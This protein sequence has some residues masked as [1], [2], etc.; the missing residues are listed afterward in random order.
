M[1]I[2]ERLLQR[3]AEADVFTPFGDELKIA[4]K[5]CASTKD[6]IKIKSGETTSKYEI[7]N[8]VSNVVVVATSSLVTTFMRPT[9]TRLIAVKGV[10]IINPNI[11]KSDYTEKRK[12][13][14]LTAV[15]VAHGESVR[16]QVEKQ[17]KE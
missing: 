2:A 6:E 7:D 4:D 12:A 8:R 3:M 17:F 14:F 13:A 10:G 9:R 5:L 15:E 16:A 11:S 1:S